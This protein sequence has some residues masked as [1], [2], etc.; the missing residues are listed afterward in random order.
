MKAR[1]QRN[2]NSP[3][4]ARPHWQGKTSQSLRESWSTAP[5]A[6]VSIPPA[7]QASV[8]H[9][10]ATGEGHHEGRN[11]G[12]CVKP[13]G[14]PGGA[15]AAILRGGDVRGGLGGRQRARSRAR[16]AMRVRP[17]Q[18]GRRQQAAAGRGDVHRPGRGGRWNADSPA[19]RQRGI[20]GAAGHHAGG[21]HAGGSDDTASGTTAA[22]PACAGDAGLG[23]RR[24]RACA[25]ERRPPQ[26]PRWRCSSGKRPPRPSTHPRIR[27]RPAP[28]CC[29]GD[30][31]AR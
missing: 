22:R 24:D 2:Q 26:L 7:P 21:G 19:E 27:K 13:T 30:A 31:S 8:A 17:H 29:G 25:R 4:A 14:G 15:R 23:G 11:A 9:P 20:P 16:A 6:T 12:S 1:H 28:R 10:K 18:R 3:F 5:A